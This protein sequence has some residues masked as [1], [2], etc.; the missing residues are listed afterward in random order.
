MTRVADA[1]PGRVL[2]AGAG[3][4]ASTRVR[5]EHAPSVVA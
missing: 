1:A 5:R 3:S 2:D 4:G